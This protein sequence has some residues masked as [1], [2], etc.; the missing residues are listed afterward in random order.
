MT[1]RRKFLSSA[2]TALASLPFVRLLRLGDRP[3]WIIMDWLR[4]PS[5]VPSISSEKWFQRHAPESDILK[6]Q[7]YWR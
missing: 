6:Y 1:T 7:K 5:E 3:Q 4:D 2:L